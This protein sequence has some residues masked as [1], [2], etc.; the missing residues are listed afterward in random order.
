MAGYLLGKCSG[1]GPRDSLN[2]KV[3]ELLIVIL[4]MVQKS[5]DHQ[6]RLVVYPIFCRVFYIPGGA[7]FRNHQR[8]ET[9]CN[10]MYVTKYH[11]L[12]CLKQG[13]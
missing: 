5:G 2:L 12:E 10:Y 8:Y 9:I 13:L 1:P 11:G 6:L 7:G 3:N 4:L